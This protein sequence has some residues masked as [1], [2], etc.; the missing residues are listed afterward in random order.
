MEHFKRG[1]LKKN[2]IASFKNGYLLPNGKLLT[3]DLTD[4]IGIAAGFDMSHINDGDMDVRK[5]PTE[6]GYTFIANK[7]IHRAYIIETD[8][9]PPML[10]YYAICDGK[11]PHSDY[12]IN[13]R[14]MKPTQNSPCQ[15]PIPY[16]ILNELM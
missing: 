7:I 13:L 15:A 4:T 10:Q 1:L 11:P 5:V 2:P 9:L 8:S 14:T 16:N 3:R 6:G 12:T